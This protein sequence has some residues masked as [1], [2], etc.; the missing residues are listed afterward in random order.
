MRPDKAELPDRVFEIPEAL[1]A[2]ERIHAGKTREP[3]RIALADLVDAL[4]WQLERATDVQVTR[5]NRDQ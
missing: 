4:I 2:A 5:P 1:H 3:I